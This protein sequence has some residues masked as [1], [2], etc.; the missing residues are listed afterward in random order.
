[1]QRTT[2]MMTRGMLVGLGALALYIGT[3]SPALADDRRNHD[4]DEC[5]LR[6][7][8]GTYVFTQ[9]G[10]ENRRIALPT[11]PPLPADL[12]TAILPADRR[13]FGY[14]GRETYDGKGTVFGINTL[15]QARSAASTN[16]TQQPVNVTP[17]VEYSGTYT[18]SPNCTAVVTVADVPEGTPD[19]NEPV[20]V[21]IYHLFLSP[22]GDKFT[23]ILFSAAV[24]QNDVFVEEAQELTGV[25]VAYRVD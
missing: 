24:V 20:F 3:A 13:P 23:F 16:L 4:R 22:D 6:S 7:L 8:K 15:A 9:D 10:F 17:F 14:A 25:G 18:V 5:N 11:T 21:S 2:T 12:P 1:M 19:P